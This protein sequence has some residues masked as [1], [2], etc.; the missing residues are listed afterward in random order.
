MDSN[1]FDLPFA[2]EAC[3]RGEWTGPTGIVVRQCCG[4]NAKAGIWFSAGAYLSSRI[5]PFGSSGAYS[6]PRA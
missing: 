1:S 5:W 2:A 3:H 6:A 4:R